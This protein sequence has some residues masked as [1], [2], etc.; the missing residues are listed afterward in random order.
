[1][2]RLLCAWVWFVLSAQLS[3]AFDHQN[4]R[5]NVVVIMTDD[6]GFSD[7]GP[8]GGEINTPNLDKL[9]AGGVKFS[10]FY[11]C[12]KCEP[13][14]AALLTGHQWWTKSPDVAIRKDT[15]NVGEVLQTAGY[16]TM[17]V[18]KWHAAGIP[19]ERGF[20]RHYGFM[21]G[22]T[23]FFVGDDSFTLDGKP[24]PVPKTGFYVTTALTDYA[25]KFIREEKQSHADKPFFMYLA[26][27]APHA[28]IQAP[29]DQVTKYRG[30]YLKG[31]DAIRR[32]RF[33]KQKALG[34]AGPG[35]NFPA[36]PANLA[37][38]DSLD[39]K[40]KD[41]E[42]LRMAT[43]AAMVDIVDQSVGRVL[44]TLD[45]LKLRDNTLIVFL[46]DNGASPNDRARRG[47]F[48]TPK[49]QWNTGL[50]WTHASSTPFKFYKR[51]QHGGGVTTP[52]I[53]NWPAAIKPR[54]EYEDQACHVTDLIPTLMDVAGIAYPAQFGGM[55]HPPL[56]GRSFAPILKTGE[57]LPPR[58]MHFA[59]FN[60]LALIDNGWKIVTAYSQPWQLYDLTKDRTETRDLA[61][62]RPDKLAELLALQ[63]AFH[64]RP[65]V[66]L[67]LISGE[68]EPE[69]AR[70]YREDGRFGPGSPESV[71]NEAYSLSLI[72]ARAEGRQLTDLELA[73]LRTRAEKAN[74]PEKKLRKE[75]EQ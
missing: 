59:L 55:D 3:L 29:A 35:W 9:A 26:Y 41:F 37:A 14:R 22:G 68:R 46:N 25:V 17:M 56:P 65:D 70:P 16:R 62:E 42:D 36:R 2:N 20:D 19:F 21:G 52:C 51:T 73:A 40:S 72:K 63:K 57:K 50:G 5:P 49:S 38:W 8:Y 11:N 32:E 53:A 12:A 64:D 28:S 7:I 45:E 44:Q 43:Y 54:T 67:R 60:N 31:W 23:D 30:K 4:Q 61:L 74:A 66:A 6:M 33:E 15:P 34:L 10:Q 13:T 69:Y 39:D 18:G 1:L 71:E 24:W 48:G 27:N 47:D 75:K 58:T